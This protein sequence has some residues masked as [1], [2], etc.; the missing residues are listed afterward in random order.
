MSDKDQQQ[1]DQASDEAPVIEKEL[2][3]LAATSEQVPP[4]APASA[5]ARAGVSKVGLL[6]LVGVLALGGGA[7][8]SYLELQ[9][10]EVALVDR[11]EMLEDQASNKQDSIEGSLESLSSDW[12]GKLD[13]GLK[14]LSNSLN[15]VTSGVQGELQRQGQALQD[16]E[17]ALTQQRA[18]LAR[19]SASDRESWLLAEAEYLLRLAN[20]R[21]VM[22]GDTVAAAALLKS[23]DGILL[24][25]DDASLH[26]ARGA[27][28]ADLAALKAVP[29]LDTEGLYLRL[30]AMIEQ[31]D[32]LVIFELR[33][34]ESRV[35]ETPADDWQGRLRQGY[36]EA[37]RKLSDYIIIRRRDV[38]MQALMDPQWEGLVRQNLRMLLEQSQVA[39]LSGNQLLYRESLERARHWVAEFF[40]ADESAARALDRDIADMAQQAVSVE[41]PDLS[42]SLRA[43]DEAV[44]AR[45]AQGGDDA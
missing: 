34:A 5:P 24:Q 2:A 41:L 23:A 21:L 45:L 13:S 4:A 42:R 33:D 35:P 18:E 36:E 38:P 37:L 25:L 19:Y 40:E 31:A 12:Q 26:K 28:A 30:A 11:L 39:L 29:R 1:P 9:R 27:V 3:A 6:A 16:M 7:Y 14:T 15:S 20:Q 32:R 44:A 8:W 17:A 22:A 10:R 43:L